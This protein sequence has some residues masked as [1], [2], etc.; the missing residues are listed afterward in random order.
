MAEGEAQE[1]SQGGFRGRGR[2]LRGRA[3][4]E[5]VRDNTRNNRPLV[6]PSE[7]GEPDRREA[8][9][10]DQELG[11]GNVAHTHNVTSPLT[12]SGSM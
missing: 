1:E 4:P 11:P 2:A 10:S 9:E 6:R 5:E 3:Q 7:V 12:S 8:R